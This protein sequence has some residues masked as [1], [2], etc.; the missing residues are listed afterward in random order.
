ME[1]GWVAMKVLHRTVPKTWPPATQG[2]MRAHQELVSLMP[3][4]SLNRG[5]RVSTEGTIM[6]LM[7]RM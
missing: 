7:I 6:R 4:I 2:R 5:V 1:A 3:S